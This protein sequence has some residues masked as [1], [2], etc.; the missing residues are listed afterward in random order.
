M[1]NKIIKIKISAIES[2]NLEVN[3]SYLFFKT[4]VFQKNKQKVVKDN[5]ID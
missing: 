4:N 5:L 3:E 2:M 1:D